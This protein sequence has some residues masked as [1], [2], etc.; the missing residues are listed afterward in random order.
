MNLR[1][2]YTYYYRRKIKMPGICIDYVLFLNGSLAASCG[3]K[4]IITEKKGWRER[5]EVNG[6]DHELC[7]T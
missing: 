5:G 6:K 7:K 1:K 2:I 3:G 4:E